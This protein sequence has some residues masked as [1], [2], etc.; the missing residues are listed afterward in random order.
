MK[1]AMELARPAC[2]SVLS[3]DAACSRR[4]TGRKWCRE[5]FRTS[6]K[7]RKSIRSLR[8]L[9]RDWR[10]HT[11]IVQRRKN[12]RWMRDSRGETGSYTRAYAVNVVTCC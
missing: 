12:R 5:A 4:L 7:L 6:K 10:K 2:G 3:R 8:R 11:R 1:K 9:S